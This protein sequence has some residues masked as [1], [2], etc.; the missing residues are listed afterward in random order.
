MTPLRERMIRQMRLHRLAEKTQKTYLWH[1]TSLARHYQTPPDQLTASQV[2]EYLHHMLVE[3]QLAWPTANQAMAAFVFFYIKVLDW[4]RVNL[5]LPPRKRQ[6]KLPEVWPQAGLTRL[7]GAP[8]HLKHRVLLMTV[9]AAG[10][11]VSEVVRL[12]VDDLDTEQMT[13]RVHQGKGYKDRDTLLSSQLLK[14]LRDYWRGW[15]RGSPSR[16]IFPRPDE[17]R[18]LAISSVQKI[19]HR[20][21]TTIGS[22]RRGGIHSLRHSFATHLLEAGADIRVIQHLMGHTSIKTTTRYLQ[23]RRNHLQTIRSPLD[24]LPVSALV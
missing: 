6:S 10:L 12:T 1:I 9:Y 13:I 4:Q 18:P 17:S 5:K 7:F 8:R 20:A 23:L 21:C 15:R 16:L 3:R 14:R 24:L 11:R 2:Q 19:Y 22:S